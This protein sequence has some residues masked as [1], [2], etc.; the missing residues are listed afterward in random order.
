MPIKLKSSSPVESL[1]EQVRAAAINDPRFKRADVKA[2]DM[3]PWVQDLTA[4]DG[5]S[6]WGAIIQA[7]DGKLYEVPFTITAGIVKLGDTSR[8]VFRSVTY[9]PLAAKFSKPDENPVAL[10]ARDFS[11][12]VKSASDRWMFAPGGTH[13]ITPAAGE[14]SAEVTLKIDE[15]T[16]AVL[17]ASLAKLNADNS[18]QR[19]FFDKE[20]D[21]AAGATAWPKRFVWSETPVTGIYCEHEPTK[22]GEELVLGKV[23][24]AFSPSF[25]SDAALPKSIARGKHVKIQAGKRGSAENPAR[26][27]GLV[28]PACGTLTNNPAFR[29]ILPLWANNAPG[30][31]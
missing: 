10:Q 25:Y 21:E 12:E 30:A 17:N 5:E 18:P 16:A 19:A 26:M 9:L 28:F 14:G 20:H 6:S 29:K 4:P 3:T 22:F 23:I 24:R 8:E 7:T 13:T 2:S 31:K 11:S 1:R 15:S 27:I